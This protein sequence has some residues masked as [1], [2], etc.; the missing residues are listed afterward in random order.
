MIMIPQTIGGE[1]RQVRSGSGTV[2]RAS[3][4]APK[5]LLSGDALI[6]QASHLHPLMQHTESCTGVI[7]LGRAGREVGVHQI[8][9]SHT[10]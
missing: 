4:F 3:Q 6:G 10:Y 7:A 8:I 9:A 5:K 2:L 1:A